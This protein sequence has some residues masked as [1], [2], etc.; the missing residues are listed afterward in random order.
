M[1]SHRLDRGVLV[2][3]VM[4]DPGI[5]GR[6]ELAAEIVAFVHRHRPGPV[7]V[8]IEEPAATPATASAV[9]R[10]HRQCGTWGVLMSA[11]THS[12]PVRRLLEASAADAG[13]ARLVVHPGVD[14]AISAAYEEAA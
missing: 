7:L 8:V 11:A 14:A 1:L 2:L 13:G 4:E 3:T 12:A 9:L 10:A 5:G 6:A